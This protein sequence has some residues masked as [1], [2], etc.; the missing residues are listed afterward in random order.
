M[1]RLVISFLSRCIWKYATKLSD[2]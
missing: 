2:W 1:G